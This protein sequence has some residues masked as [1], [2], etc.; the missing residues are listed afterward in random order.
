MVAKTYQPFGLNFSLNCTDRQPPTVSVQRSSNNSKS[1]AMGGNDEKLVIRA[2]GAIDGNLMV[3]IRTDVQGG[4]GGQDWRQVLSHS[5]NETSIRNWD[6]V[7]DP[8]NPRDNHCLVM[9]NTPSE[10]LRIS[11]RARHFSLAPVGGDGGG[12]GNAFQ[13]NVS[14]DSYTVWELGLK[15]DDDPI[16]ATAA[17]AAAAAPAIFYERGQVVL[18]DLSHRLTSTSRFLY[19]LSG[20]LPALHPLDGGCNRPSTMFSPGRRRRPAAVLATAML[21]APL[22]LRLPTVTTNAIELVSPS[23]RS[24]VPKSMQQILDDSDVSVP[25][26]AVLPGPRMAVLPRFQSDPADFKTLFVDTALFADLKGDLGLRSHRPE[27]AGQIV[28]RPDKPWESFGLLD[29][30]T[31]I[32][33]GPSDYRLYYDT[34]W[35]IAEGFP[36]AGNDF[37]RYTCLALSRD[38]VNWTKP[39]LGLANFNGSTGNNIVWPLDWQDNTAA[40][41]TVFV[42]TNPECPADAKFKMVAQWQNGA[43]GGA[44]VYL[45]KSADGLAFTAMYP[46][47]SL[48]WS[49][50]KNVM[51]WDAALKKYIAYIRIDRK[52]ANNS[53]AV[54][55]GPGRRIGR[56]LIGAEQLHD[57]TLAGCSSA[58]TGGTVQV[59]GFD[60]KD[61]P[62]ADIYTNSATRYETE[63]GGG[64]ILFFPSIYEHIYFEPAMSASKNNDGLVDIRFATARHSLDNC[65]YVPTRDGRA[66]FVPLGIN[67]CP[68][69]VTTPQAWKSQLPGEVPRFAWCSNSKED[70]DE[71][72]IDTGTKYMSSGYLLSP[73]GSEIAM[74]SGGTPTSHGGGS[75][76]NPA[77]GGVAGA[78]GS[79]VGKHTGVRRHTLRRDGFVGLEAGFDGAHDRT[80]T[81]WPQM[82]TVPLL[83]PNATKCASGDV[84]LRA[85]LISGVGGGAFFQLERSG[86]GLPNFT[87]S[88]SVLLAGNWIQGPVS[89]GADDPDSSVSARVVTP[90]SGQH[91]QIRV[92]L[93]DAELFSLSM[94]CT[95]RPHYMQCQWKHTDCSAFG[96]HYHTVPCWTDAQCHLGTCGNVAATCQ[97][98]INNNTATAES[99]CVVESGGETGPICGWY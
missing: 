91:V 53:C 85:N 33:M 88:E 90:F 4:G 10:P 62:C 75:L 24:N 18:H 61:P 67:S 99:V 51:W 34:G 26:A 84:E 44:G 39:N 64:A 54:W 73:D 94:G 82:L 40:A 41:G 83:V 86:V 1:A 96:T 11:P 68:T 59:L 14:R 23:T 13:L 35:T 5:V 38:G 95:Q 70:L 92:Y 28:L 56:C 60:D 3:N 65:E 77:G 93:R 81:S 89:W 80:G 74:F 58:G 45:M 20:E 43:N 71:S 49:D 48:S 12:V 6:C 16:T 78:V 52:A 46:N 31:V 8:H 22:L 97:K 87:L 55:P 17:A 57:W 15:S 50:T 30:H 76:P 36:N 19:E 69:L 98:K 37:H 66:P 2:V 9:G 72:S 32:Q 21:L 7:P 29:Y 47:A 27:P 79:M 63:G 25:G 42:D